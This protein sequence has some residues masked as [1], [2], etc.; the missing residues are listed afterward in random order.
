M[1]IELV[2]AEDSDKRI[3]ENL[4]QYYIYDMSEYMGWGASLDGLYPTEAHQLDDYW[5]K[6]NHFP[7]I[8]KCD[9]E[10][11]GFS[12]L[13]RYPFEDELYDMGQFFVLRK[14]KGSGVGREAFNLSISKFPGKW[15]T[16]VLD[17]NSG[18]LKFWTNVIG[19]RTNND[20]II[21]P[22]MYGEIKMNF[23]RYTVL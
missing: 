20:Y 13:R 23:I 9:G 8:I 5:E 3:I 17:N 22:E 10:L 11:A 15:L 16:R 12:L 4:W 14:F 1:K 19:E 21:T 2:K 18:A 6:D 7:Y